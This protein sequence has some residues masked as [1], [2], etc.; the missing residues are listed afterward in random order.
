MS[1]IFPP[2]LARALR[3]SLWQQVNDGYSVKCACVT[4]EGIG[5]V[6]TDLAS[7]AMAFLTNTM[8]VSQLQASVPNFRVDAAEAQR[9]IIRGIC[10]NGHG[11]RP[12]T[13]ETHS[14]RLVLR[15][16]IRV[17]VA[18]PGSPGIDVNYSIDLL[19]V[20]DTVD[21][22]TRHTALA[23]AIGE[24]VVTPMAQLVELYGDL[25]E[26]MA[27]HLPP[28]Q[29]VASVLD[30]IPKATTGAEGPAAAHS[31]LSTLLAEFQ[32]RR[33]QEEHSAQLAAKQAAAA[34]AAAES[35]QVGERRGRDDGDDGPVLM[36]AAAD[37][38]AANV[39][40]ATEGAVPP[41]LS[42]PPASAPAP[43]KDRAAEKIKKIKRLLR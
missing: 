8:L 18:L 14:G 27:Q 31:Q 11:P 22:G 9:M 28:G 40:H 35:A 41:P 1:S 21:A 12:A 29:S 13:I 2:D 7:A 24:H 4:G 17:P 37:R 10:G 16:A 39:P 3:L 6:V 19:D 43:V 25:V 33:L 15:V 26:R 20:R 23:K 30:T 32:V 36:A 38:R 5:I 42:P 34:R